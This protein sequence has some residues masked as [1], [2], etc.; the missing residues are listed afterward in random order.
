MEQSKIFIELDL[1]TS[2]I[3]FGMSVHLPR[4]TMFLVK[5]ASTGFVWPS[6]QFFFFRNKKGDERDQARCMLISNNQM[7]ESINQSTRKTTITE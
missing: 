4:Q 7:N 6:A 2:A 5:D 1:H 3:A